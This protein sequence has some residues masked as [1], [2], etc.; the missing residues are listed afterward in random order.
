MSSIYLFNGLEDG[1]GHAG[2]ASLILQPVLSYGKSGC[3][4]SPTN[5][6]QW[7]LV[8]Y[9]VSGSGRGKRIKVDGDDIVGT[10]IDKVEM[11][12]SLIR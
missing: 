2:N 9:L 7:N 8:S 1:A 5:W 6:G 3:I 11:M 10:M 12:F 4:L